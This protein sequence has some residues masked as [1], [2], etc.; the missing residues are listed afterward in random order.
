MNRIVFLVVFLITQSNFA[1]NKFENSGNA[2]IGTT[3][4]ISPLHIKSS[5][6]IIT[7][8][9]TTDDRWLY[10]SYFNSTSVR[11]AWVGLGYDLNSFNIT[12]ENGTDKILFNGG[13]VGIGTAIPSA[14]L[15]VMS[16]AVTGAE[17]V[18]KLSVSDA[19]QDYLKITN[20]TNTDGQF[21]PTVEGYRTTDNRAAL[22]LTG[23]IDA[24]ND[25]GTNPIVVFDSRIGTSAVTTRP[26]FSWDSYGSRKMLLTSNGSLG[27]GTNTTGTH[28]LAVEGSIGAREI[29][30]MAT[31]WAD[32]VFKNDYNLPTL[33]EVEK[34]IK[35][36]GHLANIPSEK[37]VLE[38]GVNLGEMN[39]KLLQ[40][41][42]EMTLY[43]IEQNKEIIDLKNRLNKVELNA[44]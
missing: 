35:E 3:S 36:N 34:H 11:K 27:I 23:S 38:N 21:I 17:T 26:L 39:A 6:D 4:P 5:S 13:K 1:Q 41:I 31:G 37:E 15:E 28:K 19:A 33:Q 44:K 22:Y 16:P 8:L 43:M 9:Q 24:K 40:K 14:D 30:V 20:G 7:A 25:N 2:G 10:T 29:K 42:E 32:F 18:L 12:V